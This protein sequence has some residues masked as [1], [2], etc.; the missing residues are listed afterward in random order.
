MGS[1][2]AKIKGRIK[3]AVGVI[4]AN[5]RPKS[6]RQT[7]QNDLCEDANWLANSQALATF[8]AVGAAQYV[9]PPQQR[10]HWPLVPCPTSPSMTS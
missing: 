4:T 2:T 8:G 1:T 9:A 10:G 5:D 6:G 3:E 7:D